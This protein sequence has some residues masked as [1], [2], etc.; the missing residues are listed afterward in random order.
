MAP[1]EVA[2]PLARDPQQKA[3]ALAL[4]NVT[5]RK[6]LHEKVHSKIELAFEILFIEG[7]W[8]LSPDLSEI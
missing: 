1:L 4:Y 2:M 3:E 8:W 5:I 6:A 7:T